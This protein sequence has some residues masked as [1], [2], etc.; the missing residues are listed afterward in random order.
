MLELNFNETEKLIAKRILKVGEDNKREFFDSLVQSLDANLRQ[1]NAEILL[2]CVNQC[3]TVD[4]LDKVNEIMDIVF[5]MFPDEL[6]KNWL[7]V[8]HVMWFIY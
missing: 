7:K 4:R 5:A 6:C 1:F 2:H 8:Y 3:F